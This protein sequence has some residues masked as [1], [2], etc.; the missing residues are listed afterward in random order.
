MMSTLYEGQAI[1]IIVELMLGIERKLVDT[2]FMDSDSFRLWGA[3]CVLHC[4]RIA[5]LKGSPSTSGQ[6][7]LCPDDEEV[8]EC[9]VHD[10]GIGS[11]LSN[12][13]HGV[14]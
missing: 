6:N 10:A 13:A 8:N 3:L 11:S 7:L 5:E 1:R 14:V 12:L 9:P 2:D 4:K